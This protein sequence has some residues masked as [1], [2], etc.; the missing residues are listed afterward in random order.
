MAARSLQKSRPLSISLR[1]LRFARTRPILRPDERDG[2]RRGKAGFPDA[3]LGL[4]AGRGARPRRDP[5]LRSR[6][7]RG[8]RAP[9]AARRPDAHRR[10]VRG[11]HHR[12]RGRQRPARLEQV[13]RRDLRRRRLEHPRDRA[14][15]LLR[16]RRPDD[17]LPHRAHERLHE[18]DDL[19]ALRSASPQGSRRGE[20]PRADREGRHRPAQLRRRPLSRARRHDDRAARG[21]EPHHRHR[22]AGARLRRRRRGTRRTGRAPRRPARKA[23]A[24]RTQAV[25]RP[26]PACSACSA[27]AC[28]ARSSAAMR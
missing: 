9:R 10:L 7:G 24:A 15:R 16:R 3:G 2:R 26:V 27:S 28:S 1:R 12:G 5:A 20:D 25:R 22:C 14:A 13:R 21:R 8:G 18:L 4:G 11:P 19:R 17:G 23:T 6:D